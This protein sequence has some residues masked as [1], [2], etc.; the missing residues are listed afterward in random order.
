MNFNIKDVITGLTFYNDITLVTVYNLPNKT[1]PVAKLFTLLAEAD[2]NVDMI[3]LNPSQGLNQIVSFS[4]MD[5]DLSKILST[6]GMFKTSFPD[7]RTDVN[8]RNCKITFS[9]E[10]M[11]TRCGVAAYV[12]D[13]FANYDVEVKLITTSETKISCLVDEA[14]YDKVVEI[15]EDK[16]EIRN[17]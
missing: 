4:A 6:I 15:L 17:V 1:T 16:F 2:I 8:S 14:Q 11:D 12:F 3:S 9:G 13:A 10:T 5:D 7:I